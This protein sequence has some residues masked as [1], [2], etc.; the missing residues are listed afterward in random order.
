[1]IPYEGRYDA[2]QP[3]AFTFDDNESYINSTFKLDIDGEVRDAKWLRTKGD[4]KI[5]VV[6]RSN[7]KLLDKFS[8]IVTELIK[9]FEKIDIQ[10]YKFLNIITKY[11]DV[12]IITN[13][14]LNWIEISSKILPHTYSFLKKKN[15][16]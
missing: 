2:L 9:Y 6:S 14:L 12:I 3:T 10:L 4:K 1:M 5:L 15:T 7:D 13:A 8:N 16:Q 11:G